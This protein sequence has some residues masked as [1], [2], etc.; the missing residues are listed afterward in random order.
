MLF[1]TGLTQKGNPTHP[2]NW[3]L[4]PAFRML[5]GFEKGVTEDRIYKKYIR[6]IKPCGPIIELLPLGRLNQ[7]A[8]CE[9]CGVSFEEDFV[10]GS[11]EEFYCSGCDR[12][13]SQ[14]INEDMIEDMDTT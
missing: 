8:Y 9:V 1:H 4:V 12:L 7:E 10:N 13:I 11:E 14:S 5:S 2:K 6:R 3:E